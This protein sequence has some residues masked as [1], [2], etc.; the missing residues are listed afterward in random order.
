MKRYVDFINTISGKILLGCDG[1]VDEVYQIVD[2]RQSLTEYT[3]I[4]NL[5][6]FGELIVKRADGG[7]GL[8]IV[9]K[10]RCSG[11]FTPNTGRVA[12]FLGLKPILT[13]LY[14]ANEIDPAF[15][16]FKENCDLISLG[17]PAVTLVFEFQDGKILMSA[18]KSVANLTWKDFVAF[19]GEERLQE[20]FSDVDILGL[21]Y[22]SLTPD[23]DNFLQ[24]FVSQYE[25]KKAPR[26]M[27]F[28]FADIKKKSNESFMESLAII[29]R[30][31]EKI[32]MTMSVNE[33]EGAELFSRFQV[34]FEESPEKVTAG[35]TALR[36]AIGIDELVIHTP[37]YTAASCEAE[38]E[39]FALQDHQKNVIRT[40]GAGDTFNG[41]YLC[42][43]LGDL[44]IKERLVIANAATAFFVTH[45][46]APTK[47]E[48]IAQIEK[49]SDR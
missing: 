39:G 3:A 35:L 5:R 45:A 17:D 29:K 6:S 42:A 20:M 1:F 13:G 9:P 33:H 7:V 41:G 47:E 25:G 19:F 14:G 30:L 40:A 24:G 49:A 31:N 36:K 18:L 8:E 38:G 32:P 10:R 4:D 48:M 46:T 28:D 34:E 11:G 2:V 37:H 22:W 23:F 44:S 27:F 16:E 15:E 21:G 12:A 43:S 26:R